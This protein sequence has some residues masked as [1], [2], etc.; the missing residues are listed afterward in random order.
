MLGI[1][2]NQ[3]VVEVAAGGKYSYSKQSH[4]LS[5]SLIGGDHSILLTGKGELWSCG[6]SDRGQLGRASTSDLGDSLK[7]I[8]LEVPDQVSRKVAID[9]V[10]TGLAHSLAVSR[11]GEAY[12]WGRGGF[13][14]LGLGDRSNPNLSLNPNPVVRFRGARLRTFE[15]RLC[16]LETQGRVTFSSLT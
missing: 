1:P 13:R 6:D 4:P 8:P 10:C 14:D 9:I 11:D 15:G 3:E 16:A 7:P 5:H 12:S 2:T